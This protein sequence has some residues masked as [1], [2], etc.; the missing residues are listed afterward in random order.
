[1]PD[2][3][4]SRVKVASRKVGKDVFELAVE[5]VIDY[6]TVGEIDKAIRAVFG[7]KVY[8]LVVDLSATQFVSSSG[9]G[10][11]ISSGK[12][13]TQNKGGIVFA[14]VPARIKEVL[15]ILGVP[16]VFQQ[17]ETPD[18]AVRAFAQAR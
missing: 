10:C 17:F 4:V 3:S 8:K 1:M 13:A 18:E 12:I 15:R 6:N 7:Q 16:N 11:F 2:G 14:R 9:I 5:G